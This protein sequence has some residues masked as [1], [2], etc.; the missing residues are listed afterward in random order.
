MCREKAIRDLDQVIFVPSLLHRARLLLANP[1]RLNQGLFG[2]CGSICVLHVVMVHR[3]SLFV[4]FL[5]CRVFGGQSFLIYGL[6]SYYENKMQVDLEER[7]A[8]AEIDLERMS[9]KL[10]KLTRD[11][12]DTAKKYKKFEKG[13]K[14]IARD[15][16]GEHDNG[17]DYVMGRVLT[18][19][20][21]TD[22]HGGSDLYEESQGWGNRYFSKKTW[23]I[24][25]GDFALKTNCIQYMLRT[26]FAVDTVVVGGTSFAEKIRTINTRFGE[27][28]RSFV[29]VAINGFADLAEAA[30]D[31]VTVMDAFVWTPG[32]AEYT[33]WV[34]FT[35]PVEELGH[36]YKFEFFS[37]GEI[38][39]VEIT[40][41]VAESYMVDLVLGN[42]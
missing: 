20:L 40:T 15:I 7:I 13:I 22:H 26:V 8:E 14:R 32:K 35:S 16:A 23:A 38:Y 10:S 3:P 30:D 36:T 12:N 27:H 21:R 5:R 42:F 9:N 4:D 39:S 29:L 28:A 34:A 31:N 6:L 17:V 25:Q 37:W 2:I 41:D 19:I 11:P 18:E 24:K 1:E 33:H